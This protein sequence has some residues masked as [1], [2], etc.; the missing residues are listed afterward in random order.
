MIL[1]CIAGL[2]TPD[3]GQIILN[4]RVLFDSEK[5]INLKPQQRKT[6]YVFQSYALFPNMSVAQ[7]I[8]VAVPKSMRKQV[9]AEVIQKFRLEGLQDTMPSKLSGG[10]KQRVS[11]ARMFTAKPELVLLDEPFSALDHQ[12]VKELIHEMKGFL[13]K[14]ECPVIFVSHNREEVYQ[15]STRLGVIENGRLGM[16]RSTKEIFT[17]PAT[18][19]E[20]KMCGC[21]NVIGMTKSLQRMFGPDQLSPDVL[22]AGIYSSDI[23]LNQHSNS[24]IHL[25]GRVTSIVEEITRICYEV[26]VEEEPSFPLIISQRKDGIT[27]EAPVKVGSFVDLFV[28][29]EAVHL[30]KAGGKT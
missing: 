23:M 14:S 1:K 8:G 28:A 5:G 15:L 11:I 30:L 18:I 21:E 20:A 26:I 10:Q 13:E 16:L 29:Q 17:K 3:K 25:V 7:N 19:E 22:A 2:E 9:V 12:L 24:K 4:N 6:G 27:E